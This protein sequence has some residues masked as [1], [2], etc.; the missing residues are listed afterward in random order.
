MGDEN[1]FKFARHIKSLCY[2]SDFYFWIRVKELVTM[3]KPSET[4]APHESD[5][6]H[7][8]LTKKHI[9]SLISAPLIGAIVFWLTLEQGTL[10]AGALAVTV[11]IAILWVTEALPLP[12]TALLIP[13]GMAAVGV[14]EVRD[15]YTAFGSPVLFLVLGGYALAVAVEVNGVD[16]WIA[17]RILGVSGSSTIRL[18]IAFMTTSALLSMLI[19][20]T[21]TTALLLPVVLGILSR[22]CADAN[23]SRLLL[24]GVAYGASIGGVATI[25]GTAPNAI[26]AGLLEIGFLE[27]LSYGLPVSITM[28]IV[29]IPILWWT[30][31][32]K[33][34]NINV[35]LDE[36]IPLTKGGKRTLTVVGIILFL[37]LFGPHLSQLLQLPT[38]LFSSA[39][40]ASIA[41]ALL[42]LTKCVNWKSLEQGVHWGVLLLL[43]GG[44]TLGQG[45]TESGAANWLAG[46]LSSGVGDLPMFTLLLVL[47]G[48]SVFATELI[49]NTAVTAKLA[50]ILMGVALQ[51]GLETDS[52]VVPVAIATSMA[53]ML[54][55]ATPPNALVHASGQITQRDMIRAGLR[56][57]LAAISVI[58]VL[59]YFGI[60]G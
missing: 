30:Y 6:Y 11:F 47:V 2:N 42:I 44:L 31:K 14:F 55:V 27:W 53:F 24:L 36:E 56:L 59:F 51:L 22:H 21:A 7:F 46:L 54:P 34:K 29:A 50:P 41:V 5:E 60:A 35:V 10:I 19:S 16:R 39:A 15:A 45:L 13:V 4:N 38:A 18:L 49:S 23:L 28:L 25:T 17:R 9:L 26:A 32:P 37:W 40:V 1:I 20:N 52:L 12:V 33:D 57:N 8:N 43:G 48:I 58:T 3:K